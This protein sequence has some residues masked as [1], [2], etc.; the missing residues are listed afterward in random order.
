MK[1]LSVFHNIYLTQED[2][3]NLV[4]MQDVHVI[5]ASLPV[6]FYKGTTSEPAEEVF[7]KYTLTNNKEHQPIKTEKD[8]YIINLPQLPEDYTPTPRLT[9]DEW[10]ELSA[11]DQMEWYDNHPTP[12]SANNLKS[13]RDGGGEYLHFKEY[14]KIKR[15]N[16]VVTIIHVVEIRTKEWLM[17]SFN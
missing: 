2:V 11:I 17:N 9:D 6:W 12:M 5:G 8:G 13:V 15:N 10:R 7:C 16:K 14:S 3:A 4:D 1:I